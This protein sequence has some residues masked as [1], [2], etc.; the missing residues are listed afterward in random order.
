MRLLAAALIAALFSLSPAYAIETSLA[1][2][3]SGALSRGGS[4]QLLSVH[5]TD[6]RG[7]LSGTY[8]IPELGFFDLPI[9]ELVLVDNTIQ[10]KLLYGTFRGFVHEGLAEIAAVAEGQDSRTT[11]HLKRSPP[12]AGCTSEPVS[13]ESGD[14]TLAGT[15]LRPVSNGP[16]PGAVILHDAAPR[17]RNH[18]SYRVYGEMYCRAGIASLIY[19]KR[20]VGASTGNFESAS[21][22]DLTADAVAAYRALERNVNVRRDGIGFIGFSHGGW[23]GPWAA[24]QLP[25]TAFVVMVAG[26]SVQSCFSNTVSAMSAWTPSPPRLTCPS[27]RSTATLKTRR[28]YSSASW[29]MLAPAG[30]LET[31]TAFLSIRQNKC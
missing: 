15:L 30:I 9:K 8:E 29:A 7:A 10:L 3:W 27:A 20:G 16:H 1:G 26:A 17:H 22:E 5:L 23:T 13:F 28:N 2:H 19:D 24:S 14:V 12:P 31:K 6:D 25:N 18:R 21:L 11:L 4:V